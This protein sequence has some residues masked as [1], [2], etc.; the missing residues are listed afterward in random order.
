M[1]EIRLWHGRNLPDGGYELI[2]VLI[3][4]AALPQD[5]HPPSRSAK[6]L[7]IPT[8][9]FR[10]LCKLLLPE[11]S[12]ALRQVRL[13][14]ALV[15]MPETSVDEYDSLVLRQYDVWASREISRMQ[16]KSKALA[17]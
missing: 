13:P 7:L 4:Q 2:E 16:P 8:V 3:G 17:V 1:R 11:L 14:A 10:I 9:S 15:A 6:C 12:P 5:E